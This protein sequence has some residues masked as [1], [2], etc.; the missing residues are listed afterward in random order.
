MFSDY[1][2]NGFLNSIRIRFVVKNGVMA[3][4]VE[5][6]AHSRKKI[7]IIAKAFFDAVKT[8][9]VYFKGSQKRAEAG[10]G[11]IAYSEAFYNRERSA[12]GRCLLCI[13]D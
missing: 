2:R 4:P 5:Y 1:R 6:Y 7:I 8:E 11:R 3:G 13:V 12:L 10:E 9:L